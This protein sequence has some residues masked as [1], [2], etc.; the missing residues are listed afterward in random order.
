VT[1]ALRH[2]PCGVSSTASGGTTIY[3]VRHAD[4]VPE[5]DRPV[6]AEGYETMGLSAR[7]ERQAVALADRLLATRTIAALYASPARRALETAAPVA[8]AFGLPVQVDARLREVGRGATSL[9]SLPIVERAAAVREHLAQFARVAMRDGTWSA[10]AG[11]E[12]PKHVRERMREAV[13]ELALRHAD[14]RVVAVSH[15]GAI[16]AFIAALLG[17]P[18]D[19]FFPTKNASIS[20][21]RVTDAGMMLVRLNDAAHLE[22]APRTASS[23]RPGAHD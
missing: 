1:G 23:G 11:T 13:L 19:F 3:L 16:N 18:R 5:L 12:S 22:Q 9:E 10:L 17:I 21:V 20:V 14:R 6:D 4:A 2:E 8:A 7:G 15:A